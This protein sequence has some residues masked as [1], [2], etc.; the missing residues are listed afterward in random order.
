M[1]RLIACLAL[2]LGAAT[3]TSAYDNATTDRTVADPGQ[4]S[5]MELMQRADADAST[6]LLFDA[7][8]SQD[9]PTACCK[10]CRKG[11]ACGDTCIERTKQCDVGPGCACDG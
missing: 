9:A 2:A 10:V 4:V 6:N 7:V 3:I 11:K 5:A 8:P 1:K